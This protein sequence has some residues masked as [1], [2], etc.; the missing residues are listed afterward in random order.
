MIPTEFKY[1]E[2]HEWVSVQD[3]GEVIV[4]ITDFAAGSLGDVVF[5]EL[6]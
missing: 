4:G 3:D 2:E 1:S 6:E 5:V